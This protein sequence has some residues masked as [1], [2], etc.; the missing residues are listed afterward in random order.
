MKFDA[1]HS[2]SPGRSCANPCASLILRSLGPIRTLFMKF[3]IAFLA[4]LILPLSLRAEVI[5][6]KSLEWLT[7]TSS[8]AGIYIVDTAANKSFSDYKLTLRLH[9]PLKSDPSKSARSDYWIRPNVNPPSTVV[10]AGDRFLVFFAPDEKGVS[11]VAH[12]INLSN[13]QVAGF[14][15][16]AINAAFQRVTD[17]AEI[18]RIVRERLRTHPKTEVVRLHEYPDTR[19]EVPYDATG[20]RELYSGSTCYLLVPEDLRPKSLPK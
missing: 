6:G 18:L 12:L 4:L 14:E 5:V 8:G 13:T 7:D 19:V 16:V 3:T 17:S 1:F 15:S 9:Q 10:S 20:H 2:D 11:Q